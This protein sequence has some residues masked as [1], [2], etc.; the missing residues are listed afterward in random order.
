MIWTQEAYLR[1]AQFA[2]RAHGEQR[3][4]TGLPYVVHITS[5]AMEVIA[6]L[7]LE[8]GHDEDLAVSSALLHDLVEDTAVSLSEIEAAFGERVARVVG[9]LTKD[10]ALAKPLAMQ[11][12]LS[13]ILSAP[14]E[15]SLVKLADR[16]TNLAPP[17]PH[18]SDAKIASYRAEAALI[19]DSLGGASSALAERLAQRIAAYPPS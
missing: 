13:R 1:A 5:V 17:P 8:P 15:A 9:A 6:A 19:L 16:I 4:P 18:W 7:R 14:V 3:T 12:S 10:A 2:A 11:D